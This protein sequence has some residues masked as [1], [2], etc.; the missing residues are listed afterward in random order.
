MINIILISI[1]NNN[2]SDLI[3]KRSFQINVKMA[4]TLFNR[5][6]E[7]RDKWKTIIEENEKEKKVD[8]FQEN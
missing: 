8:N 5:K 1:T 4:E 7:I 3:F 6:H 2:I